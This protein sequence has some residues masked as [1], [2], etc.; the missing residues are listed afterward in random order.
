MININEYFIIK[1]CITHIYIFTEVM[2]NHLTQKYKT[3]ILTSVMIHTC[4]IKKHVH[5][6]QTQVHLMSVKQTV[7][8]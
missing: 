7:K 8:Y 1:N 6:V 3:V 5:D 2:N 4:A